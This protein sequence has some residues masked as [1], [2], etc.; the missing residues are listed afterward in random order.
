[1]QIRTCELADGHLA[2]ETRGKGVPLILIHGFPFDMRTWDSQVEALSRSF[3]VTRYDLRGFGQSSL[4]QGPYSHV[5][6]LRHLIEALALSNPILI[7]LSLG[8]N[9]ALT[10]ALDYPGAVSALVLASPGLAGFEWPEARPPDA[11]AAV[12]KAYG[13]DRAREFWLGHPLFSSLRRSPEAFE[14]VRCMVDDYSGWHWRNQNPTTQA[15]IADRLSECRA[16]ALILSG[17]HDVLGYRQIARKLS[18][19]IWGARL[20]TFPD[21]GHVL[22]EEDPAGFSSAVEDFVRNLTRSLDSQGTT[23]DSPSLS[24]AR[25]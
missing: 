5:D 6:D 10:V 12:A 13:V 18:Q 16:P 23:T 19:E 15:L 4:P 2:F 14:R 9:I 3:Q 20:L 22:N 17:D 25:G 21:A 24:T 8:A 7:G 11:A 1:M